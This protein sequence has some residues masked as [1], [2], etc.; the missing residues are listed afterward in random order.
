[1]KPPTRNFRPALVQSIGFIAL[2]LAFGIAYT[3]HPLYSANQNSYFLHGLKTSALPLLASDWMANTVDPF[4]LFSWLVRLTTLALSPFAFYIY[5]ALVLGAYAA[6]VLGIACKTL[7]I[8]CSG[9]QFLFWFVLFTGLHSAALADLSLGLSG[10]NVVQLVDSGLAQQSIISQ[11]FVPSVFGVLLIVSIY[12]FLAGRRL[13]AVVLAS[14]AASLHNTYL[15]SSAILILGYAVLVIREENN[16][17]KGLFTALLGFVLL[18]PSLL[19]IYICFRPASQQLFASSQ[20]IL[21]HV[22][23][24]R[25]ADP[26]KWS[27]MQTGGTTAVILIGLYLAKGRRAFLLLLL[28]FIGGTVLTLIQIITSNNTLALLFP[29]RISTWL[30]PVSWGLIVAAVT[31]A[32]LSK[33]GPGILAR[34]QVV[35]NTGGLVLIGMLAA[36]G[37]WKMYHQFVADPPA[38]GADSMMQFISTTAAPGQLYLVPTE[39]E[40]FRLRAGVPILVDWKTHPYKDT[41]VIEWHQRL[42]AANQ[43]Y[44]AEGESAREL[45]RRIRRQYGVT[46]LVLP[47]R[48]GSLVGGELHELYRDSAYAVYEVHDQY[49]MTPVTRQ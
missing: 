34:R 17:R 25:H 10:K 42:L 4:P 31:K 11:E 48:P 28:A 13:L 36:Y 16:K 20:E 43:F 49:D 23:I 8:K 33:N 22:R 44:A 19:F 2:T 37:G 46:H 45:L 30:A 41:E 3:Q 39:M 5:Q 40:D 21:V 6:S 12:A 9:S 38:S 18:L 35:F 47:N 29:W 27:L 24:P 1:M 32:I 15:L 26:G 14:A 7:D